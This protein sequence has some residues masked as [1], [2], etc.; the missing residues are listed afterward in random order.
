MGHADAVARDW[1]LTGIPETFFIG[2]GSRVVAHVVGAIS[3]EQLADGIRAAE[4][5]RPSRTSL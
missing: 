2:P 1:G 4:A 3:V 5:G